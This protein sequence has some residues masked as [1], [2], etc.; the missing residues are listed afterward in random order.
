VRPVFWIVAGPNGSGKTTVVS[1]VDIRRLIGPVTL[2]NPDALATDVRRQTPT[3]TV[4][5]ANLLAVQRAELEVDAL[6]EAGRDVLVETILSTDKYASGMLRARARGFQIEMIYVSLRDPELHVRR[7]ANRVALGG[8]DVAS[9]KIVARWERSH[10][11]LQRFVPLLDR[12]LVFDNSDEGGRVKLIA[13]K[14]RR[15]VIVHDPAALPRVTAALSLRPPHS[16]PTEIVLLQG[17]LNTNSAFERVSAFLKPE[18]FAS[19]V[20]GRIFAAIAEQISN[21]R[22]ADLAALEER[23]RNDIDLAEIGGAAYLARFGAGPVLRLDLI[24][25]LGRTVLELH[26]KRM[27][28]VEFEER[29]WEAMPIDWLALP[30]AVDSALQAAGAVLIADVVAMRRTGRLT[31]AAVTGLNDAAIARVIDELETLH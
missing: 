3:L 15:R 1:R 10:A 24:E 7:V 27:A 16:D 19:R 31:D 6:I 12:L 8:H 29:D 2:I 13:E 22:A 20:H 9:D 26:E 5:E 21:G 4:A 28:I 30:E 14:R 25:R 11:N 17:I 23:L 18:H